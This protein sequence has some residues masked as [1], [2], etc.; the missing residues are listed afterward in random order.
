MAEDV[1][2]MRRLLAETL[3]GLYRTPGAG[4]ATGTEYYLHGMRLGE[5][6]VA[7]DPDRERLLQFLAEPQQGGWDYMYGS[8]REYDEY[9]KRLAAFIA[10]LTA[11][12]A[13]AGSEVRRPGRGHAVG[14]VLGVHLPETGAVYQVR[15]PVPRKAAPKPP[16]QP[17]K[18][19]PD[20]WQQIRRRI[21]GPSRPR[22]G[23]TRHGAMRTPGGS[24]RAPSSPPPPV[25]PVTPPKESPPPLKPPKPAKPAAGQPGAFAPG[26]G[27]PEGAVAPAPSPALGA[28][29]AVRRP[30]ATP[31]APTAKRPEGGAFTESASIVVAPGGQERLVTF[32]R[33]A[34]S[35]PTRRQV[36]DAILKL[37]AEHGH[38]FR[39]LSAGEEIVVAVSF[40]NPPPAP[41]GTTGGGVSTQA[42]PRAYDSA[43][44]YGDVR[45]HIEYDSEAANGETRSS[46][47]SPWLETCRSAGDLHMKHRAYAK[48]LEAYRKALSFDPGK[49]KRLP[50]GTQ[51]ALY[52][53]MLQAYLALGQYDRAKPLLDLLAK[54]AMP[55]AA[56][57]APA[58]GPPARLPQQ[59]L[60]SV[61][62]SDAD[63]LA[64]GDID[65]AAFRRRAKVTFH[66]PNPQPAK[67]SAKPKAKYYSPHKPVLRLED[68]STPVPPGTTRY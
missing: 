25:A 53:Q 46:G 34:R 54:G 57:V 14:E 45:D 23:P 56:R 32:V 40:A 12:S 36:V 27:L 44:N 20:R 22:R 43:T 28:P 48:A 52:R 41:V 42:A 15:L 24:A 10:L 63:A 11:R 21:R 49:T 9:R 29:P 47:T 16:P 39:H 35:V 33:R 1:E 19:K 3:A 7:T 66:D 67:P 18:P 68:S 58:P 8:G 31:A 50:S 62:K 61:A 60:V 26:T 13:D 65:A 2:I 37:L 51:K 4:T 6:T 59:L 38:K 64:A 5:S 55:G 30:L 17:A